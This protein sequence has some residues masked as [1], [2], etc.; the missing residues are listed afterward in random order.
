MDIKDF[1]LSIWYYGMFLWTLPQL[2]FDYM[3]CQN[4]V[5]AFC[6]P[7]TC[8]DKFLWTLRTFILLYMQL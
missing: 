5:D 6:G 8:F 7:L 3:D 2:P 4:S 1:Q